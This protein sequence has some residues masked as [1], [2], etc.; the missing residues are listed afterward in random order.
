MTIP[1][2]F[3]ET[4]R[5]R[6]EKHPLREEFHGFVANVYPAPGQAIEYRVQRGDTLFRISRKFKDCGVEGPNQI[7]LYNGLSSTVIRPGQKLLIPCAD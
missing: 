6:I 1:R 3:Q 2:I 4:Y 7:M 5:E